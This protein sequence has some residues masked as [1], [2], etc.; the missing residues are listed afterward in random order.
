MAPSAQAGTQSP[1]PLHFSSSIR[2]I[3]LIMLL[4]LY[5]LCMVLVGKSK[6]IVQEIIHPPAQDHASPGKSHDLPDRCPVILA[7]AMD[8]TLFAGRFRCELAIA[9]LCH[10]MFR[11]CRALRA[12]KSLAQGYVLSLY[13]RFDLI[14][15]F[16]PAVYP[17]EVEQEFQIFNLCVGVLFH[18]IMVAK[19]AKKSYDAGQKN[20]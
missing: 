3:F 1:Q 16:C 9:P 10:C 19:K 13:I 12:K 8:M 14:A 17:D 11:N 18:G 2:T 4:L 5:V 7:V 20:A 15:M 6:Q